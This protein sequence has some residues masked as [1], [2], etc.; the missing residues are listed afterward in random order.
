MLF[1]ASIVSHAQTSYGGLIEPGTDSGLSGGG[2]S[3]FYGTSAGLHSAENKATFIGYEAGMNSN[4]PTGVNTFVG[5]KAGRETTG[6]S[7]NTFIGGSSGADNKGGKENT[8]IGVAAGGDN[9]DGHWNVFLGAAAGRSNAGGAAHR[10]TYIGYRAGYSNVA[11]ALNVSLGNE[12]GFLN[13]GTGNVF[14]GNKAGYNEM[15]SN[16]LYI[17]NDENT[18][19][20]YGDFDDDDLTINGSLLLTDPSGATFFDIHG[21]NNG[22]WNSQIRFFSDG[23]LRH[24]IADDLVND[25]LVI[26][27]GSGGN[28][29]NLVHVN[30]SMII[31][32]G[33][34]DKTPA[35][36][37][38]YVIDWADYVFEDNYELN[39]LKEVEQFVKENKHL[40]NVPSAKEVNENG[41]DMV[42]MDATLLRQIEE[43]WLHVIDLKKENET[44]KNEVESLRK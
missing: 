41:I 39:S 4:S 33:N 35:G 34:L 42:E 36:Y 3:S 12:A 44:L 37:D 22:Q 38:L 15:G 8:F 24:I 9:V 29:Q 1:L 18:P 2:E 43:L 31:G 11:G 32:N 27:P 19:L 25:R 6:G 21:T 30:G 13:T 16:L 17:S 28:A 5:W 14:L 7:K 23:T 40:P 20:I 26:N 10:N